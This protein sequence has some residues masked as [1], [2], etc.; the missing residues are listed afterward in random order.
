[1]RRVLLVGNAADR[2]AL[3]TLIRLAGARVMAAKDSGIALQLLFKFPIDVIVAEPRFMTATGE[4]FETV[5]RRVGGTNS[6]A[7]FIE[8]PDRP[9]I[10][11]AFLAPL[12]SLAHS[13]ERLRKPVGREAQPR[14]RT[15]T[16]RT[17]S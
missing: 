14:R 15:A 7:V 17:G 2:A 16:R 12:L 13:R 1:M 3:R 9:T 4:L 11:E 5:V 8:M 6:T 10:N